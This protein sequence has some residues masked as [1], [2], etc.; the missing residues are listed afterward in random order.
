MSFLNS[1]VIFMRSIL[2][3]AEAFNK[4]KLTT[5]FMN[6]MLNTNLY[7]SAYCWYNRNFKYYLIPCL[8]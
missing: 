1:E 5:W 3:G 6:N 2:K 7:F 4:T 8:L